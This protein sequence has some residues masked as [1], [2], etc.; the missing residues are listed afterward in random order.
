MYRPDG[1]TREP[2]T[3]WIGV[4][5]DGTRVAARTITGEGVTAAATLVLAEVLLDAAR[6]DAIRPGCYKAPEELFSLPQLDAVTRPRGESPPV[7]FASAAAR[8]ELAAVSQANNKSH[9]EVPI[10]W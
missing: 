1:L 10:I 8:R 3:E 5:R 9:A 6:G 2:L 4:R 7:S